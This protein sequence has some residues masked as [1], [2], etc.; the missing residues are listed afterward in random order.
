MTAFF[1]ALERDNGQDLESMIETERQLKKLANLVIGDREFPDNL[2]QECLLVIAKNEIKNEALDVINEKN[3]QM[4]LALSQSRLVVALHS[5]WHRVATS[6]IVTRF[7]K[8]TDN[9]KAAILD[10]DAVDGTDVIKL[11]KI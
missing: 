2:R 11:V 1:D 4:Y 3:H 8:L 7:G 9:P 10:R 5:F 6:N